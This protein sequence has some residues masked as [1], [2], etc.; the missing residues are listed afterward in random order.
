MMMVER[1]DTG[2]VLCHVGI[3]RG[4]FWIDGQEAVV[5][6][7]G[8]F[9]THPDHRGR[10]IA[11][12]MAGV[13]YPLWTAGD[14]TL[15]FP[16]EASL[17]ISTRTIPATAGLGTMPQWLWWSSGD[18]VREDRPSL[19]RPAAAA[20]A[21]ACRTALASARSSRRQLADV[22][23]LDPDGALG[24]EFDHLDEEFANTAR[25]VRRRSA[26]H[27][28]W[29]WLQH[30]D[31]DWT[32]TTARDGR[33]DLVGF[34]V[35][36]TIGERGRVVDLAAIDATTQTCLLAHA[37]RALTGTAVERVSL[38]LL[39]PRPWSARSVRRIGMWCRG[40]GPNVMIG[41]AKLAFRDAVH[42]RGS[43]YLTIGDSDHV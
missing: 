22:A 35:F 10:R 31:R 30:P 29:R 40:E 7:S 17:H 2:E 15:A 9:M 18:A 20:V 14:A 11:D 26:R 33:G 41:G 43:W 19:P 38:E 27:V 32:L 4:R 25:C 28:A 23:D 37:V 21:A 3:E 24:R 1:V 36:G 39:D 16:S 5:T 13:F 6:L 12:Q 42:D 34:V 8:D